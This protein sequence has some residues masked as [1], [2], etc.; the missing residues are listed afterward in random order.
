[1]SRGQRSLWPFWLSFWSNLKNWKDHSDSF[2]QTLLVVSIF[3]LL[4]WQHV[5]SACF[6]VTLLS[7]TGGYLPPEEIKE[8]FD[9]NCITPVSGLLPTFIILSKKSEIAC[10]RRNCRRTG[11]DCLCLQGT[12][13]MDNLA[14]CLRYYV[15]DRLS[16]DP[17]WRN[18]TVSVT[19]N[20]LNAF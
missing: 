20:R 11:F 17:G 7:S 1:M 16:N 13:F 10:L 5:R 2:T 4:V 9:S 15:A 8:R 14:K 6:T 18:V 19:V 3:S 12:E